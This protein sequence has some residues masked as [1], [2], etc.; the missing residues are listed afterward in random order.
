MEMQFE[1]QAHGVRARP[2]TTAHR[3]GAV[4]RVIAAMKERLGDELSHKD[5]ARLAHLSPYHFNR[6]FREITGL[7]PL[8]FLYALRLDAAKRLLLT[9]RRSITDVCLDVG[10]NSLGTFISRFTHAVG[11]SPRH[12]RRLRDRSAEEGQFGPP[13]PAHA[14]AVERT[15]LVRGTVSVSVP[16]PEVVRSLIFVGL[17]RK[18]IPEGQPA[19]CAV[20]SEAGEY[21]IGPVPDGLYYPCAL[22]LDGLA[23]PLHYLLGDDALRGRTGPV[24]VS[25]GQVSGPTDIM[26]RAAEPTDPPI[27]VALPL[28]ASCAVDEP[29]TTVEDIRR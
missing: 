20:L 3:V 7:P 28:I 8:Q 19:G 23:D 11:R 27:L 12:F 14:T 9:T 6:V 26:L 25:D 10:Y 1:T 5:M 15:G 21:R 4:R 13:T 29:V 22:A 17:F 2:E 16:M 24:W 18:P